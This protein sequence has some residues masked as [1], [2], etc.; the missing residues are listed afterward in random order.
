MDVTVR[1]V[2]FI[3]AKSL[4]HRL[5]KLLAEE[6]GA[7]HS[8]LLLHAGTRWLS[9]GSCLD[10]VYELRLEIKTLLREN[11]PKKLN[12]RRLSDWF[13]DPQFTSALAYLADVFGVLNALNKSMQGWGVTVLE[14]REKVESFQCKLVLW[15]RRVGNGNVVNF[16]NLD[17]LYTKEIVSLPQAVVSAILEHLKSLKN[18]FEGYFDIDNLPSELWVRN[19]FTVLLDEID[20]NDLAKDELIDLRSNKQLKI[21]FDAIDISTF[22]CEVGATHSTLSK[23]A[24]SVLVPF[25]TTY[26]C[27]AGFSTMVQIKDKYR[28]RLDISHD[29][30]VALSKTSPRI[31]DLVVKTQDQGA[32]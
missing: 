27:E 30:R 20:D 31:A 32:H 25:T 13:E 21:K 3:R 11:E 6:L 18:S 29:M 22:W 26:L 14:A 5:F 16:A 23:R 1:C 15:K 17:E 10:R 2:N 8:I 12:E 24:W 28:N 7:E 19:P 4:N 9:R